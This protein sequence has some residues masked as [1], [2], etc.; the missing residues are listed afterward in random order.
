M[1]KKFN[2][3][4]VVFI[5]RSYDEYM[6][7][8]DL[9]EGSLNG[10]KILDCAAGASSFTSKLLKNGYDAIAVDICY[11][12]NPDT[13]KKK[14][15]NDIQNVVKTFSGVE[16]MYIWNYFKSLTELREHRIKTYQVFIEDYEKRIENKYI[17]AALP[18]LPF[19]NNEFSLIL[20]SHFLFL[21]DDRLNYEFHKNTIS[22]MLRV[23]SDE[24]RIFPLIGLNGKKS[25]FVDKIIKYIL[26]N[27]V[28]VEII[29]VPYEFVRGG[30][31][32]LKI[33]KK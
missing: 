1:N 4:D 23:S 24:I 32:M 5:G 9:N 11:G 29:K 27:K 20:S 10:Q 17:K 18:K 16:D 8:F 13:L 33:T 3:D 12:I 14:C 30:N 19:K 21:Y 6:R 26:I 31:E 7:M 28:D 2:I 22:E 15:K 25:I